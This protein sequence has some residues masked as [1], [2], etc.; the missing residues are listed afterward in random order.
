M[1]IAVAQ[2]FKGFPELAQAEARGGALTGVG[3]LG[4]VQSLGKIDDPIVRRLIKGNKFLARGRTTDE[5]KTR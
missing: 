4:G 2:S 3:T 1:V 5:V